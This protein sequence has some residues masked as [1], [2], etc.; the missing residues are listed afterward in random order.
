MKILVVE[1]SAVELKRIC[2]LIGEAAPDCTLLS[3]GDSLDALDCFDEG[4][5]LPD[6]AFL[7]IEMPSP[8]GLELAQM[9]C[10]RKP[11]LNVIFTTAYDAYLKDAFGMFAS[12]YL[13]K[14]F[15]VEDI[16]GQLEHLR[17]PVKEAPVFYAKTLGEF[18]FYYNGKPVYF[19]SARAK[20]LLAY[21]IDREG[22]SVTKKEA[23]SILFE[24]AE[25][26]S[27]KQD[28]LK[29][30][31]HALK[32]TLAQIG[33]ENILI[34]ARNSYAVDTSLFSC[35]LYDMQRSGRKLTPDMPYMEQYSW[36]ECRW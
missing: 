25:Y 26:S 36:A 18:D 21:L 24:D 34:H 4:E 19:S 15:S 22:A 9:L 16:R 14:P 33:G 2:R 12:G 20:E 7:D 17:Y 30:I 23:F 8:T 29:K 6:V 1:D 28:Y 31:V 27:S 32:T 10:Q 11:D 35:D 3:F 13:L 5:P